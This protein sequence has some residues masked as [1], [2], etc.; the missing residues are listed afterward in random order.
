MNIEQISYIEGVF[1]FDNNVYEAGKALSVT[2]TP[3][4]KTGAGDDN[5]LSLQLTVKYML[6]E[7]TVMKYGGV[8]LYHIKDCKKILENKEESKSLRIIVW[9]QALLF[10]RGIICEKL[11]G[12]DIERFFLP[13]M[14]P[15]ELANIELT[16]L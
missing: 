2:M 15:E 6:G 11:R 13:L 3:I 9:S 12:T 1:Q 8:T 7:K 10:F 4:M 5:I 16:V 14:P